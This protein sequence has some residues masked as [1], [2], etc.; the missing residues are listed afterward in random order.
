MSEESYL[1][2]TETQFDSELDNVVQDILTDKFL[3][4]LSDGLMLGVGAQYVVEIIT[5]HAV[6]PLPMV[7]SYVR[8]IINLRGQI[9]PI[10]DIRTLL[11]KSARDSD[12]IIVISVEGVQMGMLVDTVDQMVDIPQGNLS[13]MP[14]QN[15]QELLGGMCS[16]P[17]GHTMLVLD[18]PRLLH[19]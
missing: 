10:I 19:L 15:A 14:A 7:P 12:C 9:I 3:I 6:T 18:C 16:L 4:F 8:G 11:G 5:S 2:A 1:F 17:G 13:P